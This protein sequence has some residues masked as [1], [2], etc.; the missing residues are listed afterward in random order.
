ML[1]YVTALAVL[2]IGQ[3]GVR[4]VVPSNHASIVVDHSI[5]VVHRQLLLT[6][7]TN[8]ELAQV[9]APVERR[10]DRQG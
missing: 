9:E 10:S 4:C 8:A 1:T 7:P 5:Q 3:A 2:V 6:F